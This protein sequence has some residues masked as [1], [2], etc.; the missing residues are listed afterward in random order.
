M[1]D[2]PFAYGPDLIQRIGGPGL[3]PADVEGFEDNIDRIRRCELPTLLLHG[4][5]DMII[6]LSDAEALYR[7]SPSRSKE[8]V[9]IEGA[10]HNDLLIRGFDR[11]FAALRTHVERIRIRS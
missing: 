9:K 5:A 10:G 8:L 11:Y 2:S 6:P 1:L 4:T 3:T 7:A